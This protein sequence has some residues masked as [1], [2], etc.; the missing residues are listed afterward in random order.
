MKIDRL[1]TLLTIL[2]EKKKVTAPALADLLEVSTRT[3]Y[4]DI[5][6]LNLA[7]IPIITEQGIGGGIS[8][9]ESYKINNNLLTTSDLSALFLALN[10]LPLSN[11]KDLIATKSKL[12]NLIAP[13]DLEKI[14]F[15]SKQIFIDLESWDGNEI[16]K[17]EL[18]LLKTALDTNNLISFNYLSFDG[19]SS[20]RK[21]EPYRLVLKGSFWY[22]QGYCLTRNDFRT[23]KIA[24]IKDLK[25]LKTL[26]IPRKFNS[27]DNKIQS[28]SD[29]TTVKVKLLID[30]VI[31][32]DLI[33]FY[34]PSV[35]TDKKENKYLAI[36]PFNGTDAEYRYL[37]GFGTKATLL[38]PIDVKENLI[39]LIKSTLNSYIEN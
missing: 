6:T 29:Q 31:K 28:W 23:F 30:E 13:K 35:I 18:K 16:S 20:N 12:K 22:L 9:M 24:R 10:N 25:I 14:E 26:F 19:L 7:G 39:A 11:N 33:N 8:I 34:G 5:E 17:E 37:L 4:R 27:E 38:E 15:K 21:I 3:I 2:L 36:I 32:T 1:M